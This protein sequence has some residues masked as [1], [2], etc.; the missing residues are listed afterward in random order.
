VAKSSGK[1]LKDEG[2]IEMPRDRGERRRVGSG[3]R[4]SKHRSGGD[5]SALRIPA[6]VKVWQPK[7]GSY[8]IDIVPYDAKPKRNDYAQSGGLYYERTY[9]IH[10]NIGPNSEPVVCPAKTCKT[11]CPICE[12]RARV[13]KDTSLDRRQQKDQLKALKAKERQIWLIFDHKEE[14]AG[15]QLWEL[16]NYAFGKLLDK[17]REDADDE[18]VFIK[19]FDDPEAG[20]VLRVSFSEET[21]ANE[22][23][24]GGSPFLKAYSIDFRA[25]KN[26]LDPDLLDHGIDLDDCVKVLPYDELKKLFM[27]GE[28]EGD[29]DEDNAPARGRRGKGKKD[30]ED[31]EGWQTAGD[32]DEPRARS[33]QREP[34]EE[35]ELQTA[36][37]AGLEEGSMVKH[38]KFGECE[39]TRIS[40]DGT[41]LTLKDSDGDTHKAIGVADVKIVTKKVDKEDD[42]EPAPRRRQPPK[43]QELDEPTPRRG[44]PKSKQ[45]EDDD[46]PAPRGRR[47]EAKDEDDDE[48]PKSRGRSKPKDDDEW[49]D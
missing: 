26:G 29:E 7:A 48:P 36:D 38:R 30:E 21:I 12:H 39:I 28:G 18:D 1:T 25:R 27:Q 19:E 11:P 24:K 37:D 44:K 43:E 4:D 14:E 41:A 34:K 6:D 31:E 42:D 47:S 5:W 2:E 33:R 9:Y 45:D 8:T 17:R 20:A 23:G 46:E 15:V 22:D 35:D 49:E 3:E 10:K 32:E 40:S 16:S 13:M